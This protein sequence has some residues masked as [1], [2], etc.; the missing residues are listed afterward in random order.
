MSYRI[1]SR[2]TFR[3]LARSAKYSHIRRNVGFFSALLRLDFGGLLRAQR[4]VGKFKSLGLF[5]AARQTQI[6]TTQLTSAAT[7]PVPR[8]STN[9]PFSF[10]VRRFWN[11]SCRAAVPLQR[12]RLYCSFPHLCCYIY[13]SSGLDPPQSLQTSPSRL[14]SC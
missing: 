9:T 13:S 12:C 3:C 10:P 7:E 4:A 5:I 8:A 11:R 6:K 14:T 1:K 2:K